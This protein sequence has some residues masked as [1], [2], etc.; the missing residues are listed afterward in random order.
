MVNKE[1]INKQAHLVGDT[2]VKQNIHYLSCMHAV[3]AWKKLPI[4]TCIR[5]NE[6]PK[7]LLLPQGR[8]LFQICHGN[9]VETEVKTQM[10]CMTY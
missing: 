1:W 8:G 9:H 2:D 7:F 10:R 4:S 6:S 3:H 5:L